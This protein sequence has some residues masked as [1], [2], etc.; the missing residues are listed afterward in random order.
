[1]EYFVSYYDYYQPEAY[2]PSTDTYIEKDSAINEEIDKLR[3]AATYAL[4]TRR[5]VI[6]VASV[7]CIYGLGS[8]EAYMGMLIQLEEGM[9]YPREEMLKRLVEIQYERN[10]VDFHRGTFRVRGDVV[11]IFPAYEGEQALRVEFF[12]DTVESINIIDPLRGRKLGTLSKTAIYPGSHY[13]TTREN[14]DRAITDIRA[15]L[16]QTLT[17]LK[18]Q[19]KLLEY[20]RLE[21]RTNYDLEM[22]QEMGYCQGIEN[23]SRHLTGR[24]PGEPPPTLMEYL[25]K[26]ALI[27]IDESHATLPQLA[28]MFKGDRSRKETLVKYGFRMPSALD[29]RPLTF[30]EYEALPNQRIYVSATPAQYEMQKARG[31]RVEQI[32][33]PTGLMDPEVE[34]KPAH[35]QVDDLLEEIRQRVKKSERVLVTT[36]TKRM[37]ENLTDYYSG[38]GIR[39]RY[40]HSDIHTLE[41]VSIIRDL[42]LGGFDVLIGVNLLREGLDIPEVSLVAILDADKEGFLRSERSLI[43]TSGRAARNIN[44]KVIM[45]ADKIT[46]SIQACLDETTRRRIIQKKFNRDNNITPESIVKSISNVLSSIYEA[47][48]M[49]V[50]VDKNAKIDLTEEED[51]EA[52]IKKLTTEMKQAAKNLEFE[53]AADLRDQ[54]KELNNILLQLG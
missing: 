46:K 54:I 1:M 39:V 49:T 17:E 8:P 43:Q 52:L 14:L 40:L 7:S 26:D 21:Q 3:H 51:I 24:K 53:K 16:A 15:E 45:Y 32:I 48:Y 44:G 33:R 35:Y 23:Y 22:M 12:G 19:N 28:G 20:Q 47:D 4:L 9:E 34:V 25:A 13:V 10:D 11:E 36:L 42:R 5:D 41:R 18:A 50:P 37:A 27:I 2:L 6:I 31:V 30:E 38:L 29:N